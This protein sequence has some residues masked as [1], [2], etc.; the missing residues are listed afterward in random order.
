MNEI[1]F[2]VIG[3]AWEIIK[4]NM[5][6]FIVAALIAMMVSM[7]V[8]YIG[9]F[10]AAGTMDLT[11]PPTELTPMLM[12]QL[13]A[14]VIS[15][16][17][18]LLGY[19]LSGPFLASMVHMAFKHMSGQKVEVADATWG[20]SR[21]VPFALATLLLYVMVTIG[22]YMCII[23]GLIAGGLTL[24]VLPSMVVQGLAPFDALSFSFAKMSKFL[25]MGAA[26]F[27]VLGL[28]SY[29]GLLACCIGVLV[30]FPIA[31]V[32]SALVY[33]DLVGM[34]PVAESVPVSAPMESPAPAQE[35][36][37]PPQEPEAPSDPEEPKAE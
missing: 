32:G 14:T 25:V 20:V 13:R 15:T 27:F 35:S 26:L 19:A 34:G 30:T 31:A 24:L 33:R 12:Q 16:P 10:I 8:G 21:F 18:S 4:A 37:A 28:V 1:R 17:F 11:N 7:M 6:P 5:A 3:E 22:T 2:G 29:L 23:P 9:S 36:P